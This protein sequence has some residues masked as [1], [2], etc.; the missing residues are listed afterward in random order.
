MELFTQYYAQW[1]GGRAG[2]NPSYSNIP[3]FYYRVSAA[4]S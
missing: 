2:G 3:R 4:C 1:K